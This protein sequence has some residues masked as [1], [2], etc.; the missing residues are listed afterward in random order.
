MGMKLKTFCGVHFPKGKTLKA[1]KD[2]PTYVR[3]V[4]AKNESNA[5]I[6]ICS[7]FIAQ[8]PDDE[9]NY[10][11]PKIWEDHP[12]LPRPPVDGKF[13]TDFFVDFATWN[14]DKGEPEPLEV[15]ESDNGQ[16]DDAD[17]AK[18]F[19]HNQLASEE[20]INK[21]LAA[22]R[23]EHVPG[24]S[25]PNDPGWVHEDF[26]QAASNEVEKT[27]A[28]TQE[29]TIRLVY[30]FS[31]FS[32]P[33]MPATAPVDNTWYQQLVVAAVQGMCANPAYSSIHDDIPSMATQLATSIIHLQEDPQ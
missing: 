4:Q 16:N 31:A 30:P 26:G 7:D 12:G 32:F 17:I 28:G 21:Q 9:G 23:G 29:E 25:D 1:N 24:I 33:H 13:H 5:L 11:K 19:S 27:E 3:A 6:T 18:E 14:A 2:A 15:P 10:F 8:Y 22:E 20:E